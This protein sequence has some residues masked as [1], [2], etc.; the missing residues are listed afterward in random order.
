M[1]R[2]VAVLCVFVCGAGMLLP[3][4]ADQPRTDAVK[5]ARVLRHVVLFK[6]KETAEKETI[7]K[8]VRAF[9]ELPKRIDVIRDFEMGTD[10]SV[11]NRSHGFTHCFVVT[12]EN[13][14]GRD[15]YLPHPAHQE[16]VK[17]VRPWLDDVLVV[18]Y[19]ATR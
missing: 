3:L 18:D 15:T 4:E 19:W 5:S 2:L 12:F 16:F 17:L 7:D 14:K 1:Q 10:V 11:E 6:F 13:E 9:A 8:I